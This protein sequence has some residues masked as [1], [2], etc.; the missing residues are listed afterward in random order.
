MEEEKTSK[1]GRFIMKYPTFQ[2]SLVVGIAGLVATSIWQYRQSANQKAQADAAQ[3]VAASGAASAD[4]RFGVLLS[5]TRAEILDP[6]LAVSYALE[7][8]KDNAEYMLSVLANM[9]IKNYARLE[10]AYTLSCEERFGVSPGTDACN[11]P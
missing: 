11:D 9:P 3:K 4:Q 5:L 2:S 7:L 10:R 6:E 8:G 1:I